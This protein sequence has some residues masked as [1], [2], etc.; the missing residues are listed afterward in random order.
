MPASLAL[1][2]GAVGELWWTSVDIPERT[3]SSLQADLDAPARER[4]ERLRAERDRR[5]AIV[6]H[7]LLRR[8]CAAHLGLAATEIGLRRE[9]AVCGAT[10]HGKPRVTLL[11]AAAMDAAASA[12]LP[13]VSLS[14]SG[15]LVVVALGPPGLDLGVDVEQVLPSLDWTPLRRHTFGEAE[16]LRTEDAADPGRARFQSW[17]RKEAVTK[18]VGHGLDLALSDVR[19]DV[20][21]DPQ[22]WRAAETPLDGGPLA[23][24][25]VEIHAAHVAAL[26]VA[27]P[28]G[29]SLAMPTRHSATRCWRTRAGDAE[30]GAGAGPGGRWLA[31]GRAGRGRAGPG[32]GSRPGG[33]AGRA[34]RAGPG[35]GSRPGGRWL[36]ASG[37]V[38]LT[39]TVAVK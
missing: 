26:A 23:V 15:D 5:R 19:A 17:A 6:A 7:G 34:G 21:A 29:G 33:R 4:I 30:A 28:A 8:L 10:E 38:H 20:E 31:A 32:A 11:G 14:H 25:D 12:A 18:A 16:W 9:C 13:E 1:P 22:G 2:P 27:A 35:A 24:A 36:A 3:L 37:F 39:A